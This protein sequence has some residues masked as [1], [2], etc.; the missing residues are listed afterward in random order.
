MNCLPKPWLE[1]ISTCTGRRAHE[2]S[3]QCIAF[4]GTNLV[5]ALRQADRTLLAD[6]RVHTDKSEQCVFAHTYGSAT[7]VSG[8]D[9]ARASLKL[10][11]ARHHSCASANS[12]NTRPSALVRYH[13][14]DSLA[15][16]AVLAAT[17]E[18]SSVP[19][20]SEARHTGVKGLVRRW[21][22]HDGWPLAAA[23]CMS[24]AHSHEC[25]V[26]HLHVEVCS[27][28]SC[29]NAARQHQHAAQRP[30]GGFISI[31]GRNSTMHMVLVRRMPK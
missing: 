31:A 26:S 11:R 7:R 19:G 9:T 27:L 10:L 30:Q 14:S 12:Y 25:C 21:D 17:S 16:Q 5:A 22:F 23:A 4:I 1:Y 29:T 13:R 18:I 8:C 2:K 20:I 15:Q 6:F 24:Q 3:F 28:S